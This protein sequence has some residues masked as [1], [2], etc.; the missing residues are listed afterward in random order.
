MS[1]SIEINLDRQVRFG[2]NGNTKADEFYCVSG[3][4]RHPTPVGRFKINR[5]AHPSTGKKYH[6]AMLFAHTSEAIPLV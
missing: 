1:K 2:F 6:V 4:E 3:D 5:K